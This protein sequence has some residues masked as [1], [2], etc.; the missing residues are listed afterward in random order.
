MELTAL[1]IAEAIPD[2]RCNRR[3]ATVFLSPVDQDV[4]HLFPSSLFALIAT[5]S[6]LGA[7]E[8]VKVEN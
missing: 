8:V 6:S 5:E 7:G 2:I 1:Q 3:G 4:R